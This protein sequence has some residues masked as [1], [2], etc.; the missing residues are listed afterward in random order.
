[1]ANKST[2]GSESIDQIQFLVVF[3][4]C[5]YAVYWRSSTIHDDQINSYGRNILR[6][7]TSGKTNHLLKTAKRDR[8]TRNLNSTFNPN[9]S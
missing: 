8:N 3:D 5:I 9:V 2:L 6:L 1:M 7:R 4:L